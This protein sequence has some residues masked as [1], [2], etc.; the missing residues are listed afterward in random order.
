MLGERR[1]LMQ[2]LR[3]AKRKRGDSRERD[4]SLVRNINEAEGM[5][6]EVREERLKHQE[7]GYQR[8]Q[9]GDY[10]SGEGYG[11]GL[12]RGGDDWARL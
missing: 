2:R 8:E 7:Q 5:M 12:G 10:Q 6:R 4:K 3:A 11:D 9:Q 1:N